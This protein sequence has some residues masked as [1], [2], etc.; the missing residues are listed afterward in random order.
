MQFRIQALYNSDLLSKF[1]FA[2]F[3][4]EIVGLVTLG[5][6]A[7][8]GMEGIAHCFLYQMQKWIW[9]S[10]VS[11]SR[12]FPGIKQCTCIKFPS[13]SFMFWVPILFFDT[14]LFFLAV[15]IVFKNWRRVPQGSLFERGG[16]SLVTI[17]L[18]DNIG[19]FFLW[20]SVLHLRL[21]PL[22]SI[23]GDSAFGIYLTTT[24]IWLS[25]ETRYF[26]IPACFSYSITTVLGCR[27]VLNLCDAYHNPPSYISRGKSEWD[28][29]PDW[30][31]NAR[32]SVKLSLAQGSG[33]ASVSLQT[34][35]RSE[36]GT[37]KDEIYIEMSEIPGSVAHP[38]RGKLQGSI[39]T[40]E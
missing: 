1:L 20:V 2:V 8:Q 32:N 35:S 16:P 28:T 39:P 12:T 31:F 3:I 24:V 34:R 38:S 4:G 33:E 14:L 26:S 13:Y 29:R 18:R 7:M 11:Y 36:P 9:M 17:L 25:A 30:G 22:S 15:G 40:S 37:G 23:Q 10:A 5:F 19:Y 6:L 27:L 21:E